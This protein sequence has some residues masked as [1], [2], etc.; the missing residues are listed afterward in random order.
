LGVEHTTAQL[1][2]LLESGVPGVHFYA[3]NRT[4]SVSKVLENVGIGP[5]IIP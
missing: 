5:R 2:E 1:S 3:L 4:H